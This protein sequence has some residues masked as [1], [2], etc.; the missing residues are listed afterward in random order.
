MTD[1][2]S[3]EI[4]R[5]NGTFNKISK[6]YEVE[7][8]TT[9]KDVNEAKDYFLTKEAQ[10]SF[11]YCCDTKFVLTDKKDALHWTINFGIHSDPKEKAWADRWKD[12]KQSLHDNHNWF[13]NFPNLI[14]DAKNLF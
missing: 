5:K 6:I 7:D 10:E 8:D 2:P 9:F 4:M 14:H 1:L 12:A 11:K 13:N 3:K